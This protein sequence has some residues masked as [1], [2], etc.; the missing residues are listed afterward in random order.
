MKAD[1]DIAAVNDAFAKASKTRATAACSSTR[2]RRSCRPTS[3]R[4]PSSC[5]FSA[6]DTMVMGRQVKVLGWYDN[7]WGYSNRLVDLVEFIGEK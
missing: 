5:I 4:N 1:V 6:P 3:S 2:T 7:E